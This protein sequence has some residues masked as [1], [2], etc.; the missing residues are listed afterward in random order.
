MS[1]GAGEADR[2]TILLID[3]EESVRS[4]VKKILQRAKYEVLE[5]KDGTDALRVAAAHLGKIDLV[6]TDMYMPGLRG[7]EVVASLVPTRPGLRVLFISGYAG[8]GIARTNVPAG[9]NFLQKPFS[10]KELAATV[11]TVLSGPEYSS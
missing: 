8:E 9:A 10:G 5:A 1:T 2:K 11:Q 3:D 6:I 4:I 7:P